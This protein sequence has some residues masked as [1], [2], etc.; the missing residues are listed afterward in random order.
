MSSLY[1]SLWRVGVLRNCTEEREGNLGK[2]TLR[3]R[4]F[5]VRVKI[6]EKSPVKSAVISGEGLKRVHRDQEGSH[7]RALFLGKTY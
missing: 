7:R 5:T 4:K 1:K 3:K 6:L 2:I